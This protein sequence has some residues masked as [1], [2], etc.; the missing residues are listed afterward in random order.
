[1]DTTVIKQQKTLPFALTDIVGLS[2]FVRLRREKTKITVAYLPHLT[3]RYGVIRSE[4]AVI[5]CLF[6]GNRSLDEVILTTCI[7]G[8]ISYQEAK[9]TVVS[10]MN[11]V[12]P[13]LTMFVKCNE[14]SYHTPF[15]ALEFGISPD[16][17]NL[18]TRLEA[19]LVL[20]LQPTPE[21]QTDCIYCYACKRSLKH[22][23]LLFLDRIR[24]LLDEAN[25]LGIYQINLCGGDGFCR[26]DFTKIIKGCLER[27]LIVDISTKCYINKKVASE[28]AD[29]GL[30]YI[31]ISID[32]W[33]E[34]RAD[35]I[36]GKVGHF[37]KV[38]QTI[39]NLISAG[40]YTRTNSIITPYNADIKQIIEF[41]NG[42]G[43]REMKFAPAFRSYYRDNSNCLLSL[44]AKK[45]FE[46]TMPELEAEYAKQGISIFHDAMKDYTEMTMEERREYWF[47]K[48]PFCSSGRSNLII[49]PDG[50]VVLCEEAPQ[51]EGYFV[52][53]L[54]RQSIKEVWNS[55][56]LID[57]IYPPRE[58]FASTPC[59]ECEQFSSCVHAKGHCFKDCLK[60]HGTMYDANPFCP[61][62]R[63]AT[64]RLY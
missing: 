39:K 17:V 5:L 31:Q 12:S 21:C 62:S 36:Y 23:E 44:E 37:K 63:K 46:E 26:K 51:E 2:P 48:R 33:N 25:E 59:Y 56:Q 41:L 6:D 60:V 13:E 11:R 54:K 53:D 43:I 47:A 50:K 22:S 29:I 61:R 55:P 30:D 1:M 45:A 38:V 27:H 19:P 34:K 7:L 40:V 18:T 42:L 28:L 58:K 10:L 24:E 52:G 3:L 64:M 49:A 4:E 57:F 14:Q 15:N 35:Y 32:T 8:D 9:D 20:L 16:N